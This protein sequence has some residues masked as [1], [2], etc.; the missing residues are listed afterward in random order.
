MPPKSI[1]I[2]VNNNK[3]SIVISIILC[4]ILCVSNKHIVCFLSIDI[5]R[6]IQILF[7]GFRALFV[8]RVPRVHRTLCKFTPFHIQPLSQIATLRY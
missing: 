3:G 7:Q 2:N 8:W 6:D 4:Y 5:A 1:C